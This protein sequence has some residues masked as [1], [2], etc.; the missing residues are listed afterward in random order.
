MKKARLIRLMRGYGDRVIVVS[1][2]ITSKSW[3]YR[4]DQAWHCPRAGPDLKVEFMRIDLFKMATKFVGACSVIWV[5]TASS[6]KAEEIYLIR[7]YDDVFS[8]GINQMAYRLKKRGL[9]AKAISNGEWKWLAPKIIARKKD[10]KI[11]YPIII[12]GHSLGGVEAPR[13]ANALGAGGVKVALVIG[14]DPGFDP[15]VAF[16][17]NIRRVINYKIP[18]GQNYRRGKGFNGSLKTINVARYGVTHVGID[19]NPKVQSLV[20]AK[21]FRTARRR[22]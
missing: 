4:A 19:K 12:V 22:R 21:I 10:K 6:V 13:F 14:L 5:L 7:G 8:A 2:C 1:F 15:P 3:L 18:S 11:S 9:N 16:G 17:P 20:M